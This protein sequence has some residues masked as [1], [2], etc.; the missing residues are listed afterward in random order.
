MAAALKGQVV[1]EFPTIVVVAAGVEGALEG[2]EIIE[3]CVEEEVTPS[4]KAKERSGS[5]GVV[6]SSTVVGSAASETDTIIK[7]MSVESTVVI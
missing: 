2:C 5:G 3:R 4:Q 7:D 1:L 6:A